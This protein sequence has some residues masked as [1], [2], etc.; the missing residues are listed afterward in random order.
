[1]HPSS[2]ISYYPTY[3]IL[4]ELLSYGNYDKMNIFID[5]RNVMGTLYMEHAVI[6]IVENSM[7][8]HIDTSIFSS[9]I[10]FLSFH[11]IYGIKRN[12]DINYYIFYETGESFYHTNIDK[13]YKQGRKKDQLYGLDKVKRD[14]FYEVIQKNLMLVEKAGNKIPNTNVIRVPNLEADFVPYYLMKNNL[15]DNNNN[16]CNVTYSSDHDMYQNVSP[17]SFVF[18][19]H[20]KSKKI[21][22]ADTI[23]KTYLKADRDYPDNYLPLIMA[24]MGDN[25][26]DVFGIKGIGAKTVLKIIDEVVH[27]VGGIETLNDN[28]FNGNDIFVNSQQNANK[29]INK[30]ISAENKEKTISNN[31]KLVSY[32][33]IMRAMNQPINTEMVKKRNDIISVVDDNNISDFNS[34]HTALSKIGV[35]LEGDTL[36]NL[37]YKAN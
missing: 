30:I 16:V 20:Y 11:K 1:M 35:M 24:I 25:G 13:R 22:K 2:I 21:V 36:E 34:M 31:L 4:D 6:N 15:V 10:S 29:H 27:M 9:L 32:E 5:F 12:I 8:S 3:G 17:N 26:D 28:V 37:Y 23:V 19:R 33:L 14:R 7:G 18:F